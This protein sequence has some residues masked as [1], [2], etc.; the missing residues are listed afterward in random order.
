ME[1]PESTSVAWWALYRRVCPYQRTLPRTMAPWDHRPDETPRAYAAFAVYRDL[2][3]GRS[4]NAAYRSQGHA[5]RSRSATWQGWFR[6]Y[7]WAARAEAFDYENAR[8]VTARR[9]FDIEQ[10]DRKRYAIAA[11]LLQGKKATLAELRLGDQM[12]DKLRAAWRAVALA[13]APLKALQP[14]RRLNVD[15]ER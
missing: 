10:A 4:L 12:M 15:A 6:T 11:R 13:P 8:K 2:G 14:A 7:E 9:N 1:L 3:P 5:R